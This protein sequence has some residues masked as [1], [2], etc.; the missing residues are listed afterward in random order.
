MKRT[1]LQNEYDFLPSLSDEVVTVKAWNLWDEEV[2]LQ[3][4]LQFAMDE[5]LNKTVT[6]V[7]FVT[8]VLDAEYSDIRAD[9]RAS[10]EKQGY[11]KI[12]C[13]I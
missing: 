10:L 7:D 13:K 1:A 9:I 6:S 4:R 3:V 5:G 2:E 12:E 11:T 8:P